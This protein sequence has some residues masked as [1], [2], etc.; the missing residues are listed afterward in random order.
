[1]DPIDV[2]QF[3]ADGLRDAPDAVGSPAVKRKQLAPF[4][5]GPI[6]LA[7][8]L[9]AAE[10]PGKSPLLLGL[11]IQHQSR[12]Q[13]NPKGIRLTGKLL[14]TFGIKKRTAHSALALLE[15]SGLV[16]VDR[17]AGRCREISIRENCE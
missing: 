15:S 9:K 2:E 5:R 17:P 1:M 13:R 12:L 4:L 11:G 16:F 3:R 10:L 7:W 14:A 8:L 6:P